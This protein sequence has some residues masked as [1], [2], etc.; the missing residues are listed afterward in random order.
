MAEIVNLR[1]R[2]KQAE[3]AARAAK[4]AENRSRFGRTKTEKRTAKAERDMLFTCD[5]TD[6]DEPETFHLSKHPFELQTQRHTLF[7]LKPLTKELA[8]KVAPLQ[9]RAR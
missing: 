6:R 8:R 2:R 9:L 1:Q 7:L 4:A 5:F 3:R